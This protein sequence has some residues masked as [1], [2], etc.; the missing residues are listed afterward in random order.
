V[1]VKLP[2]DVGATRMIG[3]N[4]HDGWFLNL[5]TEER[6][7]LPS[8]P[9]TLTSCEPV[10]W[11]LLYSGRPDCD[12]NRRCGVTAEVTAIWQVNREPG[13]V[14]SVALMAQPA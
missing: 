6:I 14:G 5:L 9:P 12:R 2:L 10:V 4:S 13:R 1:K 7:G 8:S 11:V 3:T